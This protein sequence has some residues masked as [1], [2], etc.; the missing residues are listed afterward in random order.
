MSSS[1]SLALVR[2]RE[3]LVGAITEELEEFDP[4]VV[5]IRPIVS[6]L[7]SPTP[8]ELAVDRCG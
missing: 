1:E 7:L 6:S 8:G 2:D 5:E 3:A 4:L